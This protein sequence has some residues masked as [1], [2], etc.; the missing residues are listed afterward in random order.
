MDSGVLSLS[1]KVSN[2]KV[3]LDIFHALLSYESQNPSTN[4]LL[5]PVAQNEKPQAFIRLVIHNID[6]IGNGDQHTHENPDQDVVGGLVDE[7]VH[8]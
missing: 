6:R 1:L 3:V 2:I 5:L 8:A 4:I 7:L